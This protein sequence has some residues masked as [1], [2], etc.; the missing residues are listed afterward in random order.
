MKK[1]TQ[2]FDTDATRSQ[3]FC[4]SAFVEADSKFVDSKCQGEVLLEDVSIT[5]SDVF[6]SMYRFT[7]TFSLYGH[8]CLQ[9]PCL[10][11]NAL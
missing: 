6:C 3:C 5:C 7:S 9:A 8:A 10:C 1:K 4:G 11:T 2:C